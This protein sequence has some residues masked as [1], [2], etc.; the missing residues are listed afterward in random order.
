VTLMVGW[1]GA[2]GLVNLPGS[3]PV[4]R[5]FGRVL[6]FSLGAT[7]KLDVPPFGH[8]DPPSPAIHMD[9]TPAAIHQGAG[10]YMRYC[11]YCHGF[12]VISGSSVP[13]L[14]YAT[15]ETHHQFQSIVLGGVRE[16]RGMPSFKDALKPDQ[17]QLIQA[18]VLSQAAA[19]S[20]PAPSK[21]P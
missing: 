10:I 13:D 15:A 8:K 16:S 17:V 20:K 7:T 6:T 3:G 11:L 9:A 21:T 18:Y 14:R 12:G 4:K 2:A 19:A 5:G 1:G